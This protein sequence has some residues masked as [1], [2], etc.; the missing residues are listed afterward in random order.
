MKKLILVAIALSLSSCAAMG[1]FAR[2]YAA[3]VNSYQATTVN[4]T[5]SQYVPG[6]TVYTTCR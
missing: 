6:G 3:G 1:D 5:S 2:G 4:C